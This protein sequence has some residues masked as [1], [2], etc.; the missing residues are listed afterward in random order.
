MSGALPSGLDLRVEGVSA[1]VQ[2]GKHALPFL[3][4][5]AAEL[6][7]TLPAETRCPVP[8]LT[9]T[10]EPFSFVDFLNY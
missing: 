7:C 10:A 5:S 3:P 4:K 8:F 9:Y 2:R 1:R 6:F